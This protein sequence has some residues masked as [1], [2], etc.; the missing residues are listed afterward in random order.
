MAEQTIAVKIEGLTVAY[1]QTPVLENIDLALPAGTLT[2]IVGPNGAGKTTLV[3]TM[4]GLMKPLAGTIAFPQLATKNSTGSIAYVPQSG[5]VDWGFPATVLDVVLMG[6]Y[7]H[8]GWLKRPGQQ[9][10]DLALE[11]L[12]TVGMVDYAK[13]QISQLSGGQQQRVFLARALVQQGA[14]YVMDEPF[15]G[16]DIQTEGILVG[17]LKALAQQGKTVIVVHHNLQTVPEYFH[18]VTL[19]NHRI[20]ANGTVAQVFTPENIATTYGGGFGQR[21]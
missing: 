20:I 11:T 10:R 14:I 4:L 15:K 2:A 9:E 16:V 6:R 21:G 5:S 13:R 8:L 12:D 7:G 17:L 18:W 19:V 1:G 3:K